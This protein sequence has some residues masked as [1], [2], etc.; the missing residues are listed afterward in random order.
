MPDQLLPKSHHIHQVDYIRAMASLAV[1]LFHLGGKALPL[2]NYGWLGVE[3]FFLLSGFIIC[4]S[5]P[6]AYNLAMAKSFIFKRLLRI[7]PPYLISII[8]A[9][10]MNTILIA[11]YKPDWTN[12]LLHLAYINNF[13]DRPYLSPIYWTLGIEFQYYILV[14]ICFPFF[15]KKW[16]AWVLMALCLLPQLAS[17]PSGIIFNYFPFFVLG[18][19]YYLY[20]K[21]IK[22]PLEILILG[23]SVALIGFLQNGPAATFAAL[24]A[25]LL[26][27]SPLKSYSIVRFFSKISFSLYLTHDII[28]SRL[29]IYLGSIFHHTLMAKAIIFA[30][31]IVASIAFAYLFY[32][33]VEAPFFKLSKQIRY[34]ATS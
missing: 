15:K 6:H 28:G 2:L 31:G 20:L 23:I 17:F 13:F 30:A 1:A 27:L 25:L 26:L 3:M 9:L 5:M 21:R 11:Q 16:G 24:F 8:L 4:W 33:L 10:A 14:A 32:R 18:I 29:V 22:K 7:E 19:L 12:V 34:P